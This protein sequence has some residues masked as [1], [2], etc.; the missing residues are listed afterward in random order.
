MEESILNSIKKML[1][2]GSEYDVYDTDII[3]H[4][5]TTLLILN[6]M[7]VGEMFTITDATNTWS[8][9][10]GERT[11]LELIKSYIYMKVKLMFDPPTSSVLVEAIN[12]NISELEW[13]IRFAAEQFVEEG[14]KNANV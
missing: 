9:F 7:G 11:D 4:I 10:I 3:I 12:R 13:R 5:N 8:E 6:Q 14:D 1:G 2:I